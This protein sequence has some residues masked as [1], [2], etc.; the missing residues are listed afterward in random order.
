LQGFFFFEQ[1]AHPFADNF[2]PSLLLP[3]PS[4]LRTRLAVPFASRDVVGLPSFS[5]PLSLFFSYDVVPFC[6]RTFSVRLLPLF[7]PDCTRFSSLLTGVFSP[8]N[9]IF[10]ASCTPFP[11]FSLYSRSFCPR[12]VRVSGRFVTPPPCTGLCDTCFCRPSLLAFLL[13]GFNSAGCRAV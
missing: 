9:V 8:R 11:F 4:L 1:F 7:V 3:P 10:T 5:P 12:L 13:I 2:F 6:A